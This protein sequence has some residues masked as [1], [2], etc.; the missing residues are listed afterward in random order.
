MDILRTE[1]LTKSFGEMRAVNNVDTKFNKGQLCAVI[2]PN[3]AGKSTLFNLITGGLQPTSGHVYFKGENITGLAPYKILKKGIGRSF[4]IMNIF[5]AL[6]TFENVRI[7][8]L[9]HNKK[10]WNLFSPV[11]KMIEINEE[12]LKCLEIVR[13]AD[14]RD[15]IAGALSGGKQKRLEIALALTSQPDLLLLDEPTAG[16]DPK[17]TK[18]VTNFIKEISDVMGITVIFIEHDMDVVFS[19]SDRIVVMQQGGIIA[20]GKGLEIKNDARV[21]EAYLGVEE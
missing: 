1:G 7:G 21:K 8:I 5:P 12:V 14:E 18:R 13:L 16:L 4:Q 9:S 10:S 19:I 15:T 2:G 6:T 3:G 17:E 20:D 11:D